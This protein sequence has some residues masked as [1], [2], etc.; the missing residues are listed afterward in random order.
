MDETFEADGDNQA[1]IDCRGVHGATE[2]SIVLGPVRAYA[3]ARE[4]CSGRYENGRSGL[5]AGE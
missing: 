4:E 3:R 1:G 2:N 5:T